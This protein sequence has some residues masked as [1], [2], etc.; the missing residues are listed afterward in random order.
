MKARKT[1]AD[2]IFREIGEKIAQT[3][4]I[5]AEINPIIGN[6]T[7]TLPQLQRTRDVL[8]QQDYTKIKKK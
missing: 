8:L 2:H 7:L 5:C 1:D 3:P 4:T 6:K